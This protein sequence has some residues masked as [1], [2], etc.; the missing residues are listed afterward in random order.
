MGGNTFRREDKM[1]NIKDDLSE[2][3]NISKNIS[4]LIYNNQFEQIP[5]LELKRQSIIKNIQIDKNSYTI[6]AKRISDLITNNE[7]MISQTEQSLNTLKADHYKFD[8]R[9]KAYQKIT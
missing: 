2:L 6:S 9:M 7:Q 5:L 4:D 8:K 3:E 1:N